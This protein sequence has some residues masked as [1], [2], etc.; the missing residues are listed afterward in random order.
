MR[1]AAICTIALLLA[2]C[3]VS[4]SPPVRL[5]PGTFDLAFGSQGIVTIEPGVGLRSYA[6]AVAVDRQGRIVVAGGDVPLGYLNM[7][8]SLFARFTAEGRLDR[9]WATDGI[10]RPAAVPFIDREGTYVSVLSN[11]RTMLGER[12]TQLCGG[13]NQPACG[14]S[15]PVANFLAER[16]G[17]DGAVDPGPD[18]IV[19]MPLWENPRA[20][21]ALDGDSLAVFGLHSVLTADGSSSLSA[22]QVWRVDDRGQLDGDYAMNAEAGLSSVLGEYW[23]GEWM[24]AP[25]GA[26]RVW[27]ATTV[28]TTTGVPSSRL[29]LARLAA[30]GSLD[31][32]FASQ[33]MVNP[34]ARDDLGA[35][36]IPLFLLPR[37][38]GGVAILYTKGVPIPTAGPFP[39]FVAW[40]GADGRPEGERD[41]TIDPNL[42]GAVKAAGLLPDGRLIVAGLPLIRRFAP[43]PEPDYTRPR[44]AIIDMAGNPDLAFGPAGLGYAPLESGGRTLNPRQLL[45]A[46]DGSLF[47]VGTVP[48][49]GLDVLL[50]TSFAVAKLGS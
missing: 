42:V 18:V 5:A 31:R 48:S 39:T 23:P 25:A 41:L 38:S 16:H 27:V 21:V 6:T 15:G 3:G 28:I 44:I 24:T 20:V 7:N 4:D 19:P 32:T 17:T 36:I 40:I 49:S 14:P 1:S 8:T 13:Q 33:G 47:V 37:A 10:W 35:W 11:D 30:N 46:D 22:F 26:G 2:G 45:R 34:A 9:S 50:P 12:L 43:F 29:V